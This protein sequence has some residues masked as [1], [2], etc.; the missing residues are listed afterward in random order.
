MQKQ[1]LAPAGGK[2]QLLA[3]APVT[4][5][6]VTPVLASLSFL[7]TC[8]NFGTSLRKPH[9]SSWWGLTSCTQRLR[10][11]SPCLPPIL[12]VS[13]ACNGGQKGWADPRG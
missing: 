1:A 9:P 7:I 12:S 8:V 4:P 5:S 11:Q 3:P 10:A 2:R 6:P 13:H